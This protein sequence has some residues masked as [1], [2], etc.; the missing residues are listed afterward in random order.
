MMMIM[1][2]LECEMVC[3][4]VMGYPY[5]LGAG[6]T[7]LFLPMFRVFSVMASSF[8]FG[9]KKNKRVSAAVLMAG[10]STL[11]VTIACS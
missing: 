4:V 3:A 5:E 8:L 10:C 7:L 6:H 9:N 11:S 1:M 2:M